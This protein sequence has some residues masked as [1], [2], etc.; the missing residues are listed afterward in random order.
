MPL[1]KPPPPAEQLWKKAERKGTPQTLGF[2]VGCSDP[3]YLCTV[4][5]FSFFVKQVLAHPL[6]SSGSYLFHRSLALYVLLF[7]T[8]HQWLLRAVRRRVLEILPLARSHDKR[9]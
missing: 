5:C 7:A 4:I 9:L 2:S 6:S 1:P 8:S 3:L